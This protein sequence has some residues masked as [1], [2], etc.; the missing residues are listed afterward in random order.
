MTKTAE[1]RSLQAWPKA[2]PQPPGRVKIVSALKLLLKEKE[3]TNITWGEIAGAAGV[4]EGLI[5]KYFG[6][7]RNLL[8]Q[9]LKEYLDSYLHGVR[10][11]VE[12][13]SGPINKLRTLIRCL[14]D[15]YASDRVLA[16]ILLLE[17]RNVPEYFE[18]DAY[19]LL[20]DFS[21][22]VRDIIK[23]GVEQGEI[24]DDISPDYMRDTILGSIEP[25]CLRWVIFHKK[26]DPDQLA[27]S[28]CTILLDGIRKDLK[29]E[30]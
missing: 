9:V 14:I 23:E 20:R 30:Q 11:D 16:K 7:S 8:F 6:N 19:L 3:F 2:V 21:T 10:V 29:V 24:R 12:A 13:A 15:C 5:Y 4:N 1:K 25:V 26:P 28:F 22:W 27:Q 18:S 17:V